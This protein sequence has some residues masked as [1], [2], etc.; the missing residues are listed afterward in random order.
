M[1]EIWI[2]RGL[3]IHSILYVLKGFWTEI[4]IK[5]INNYFDDFGMCVNDVPA[6]LVFNM[7]EAGQDEYV[8]SHSM[9]VIVDWSYTKS[10]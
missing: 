3:K 5:I 7:D 8:D 2:Y 6:S 9:V 1:S 10:L 4:F